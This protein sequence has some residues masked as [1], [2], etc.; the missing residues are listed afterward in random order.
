MISNNLIA[1]GD[2]HVDMYSPFCRAICK[3]PGAT[4][5]GLGNDSSSTRARRAFLGFLSNLKDFIPIVCLGEVDCNSLFW[6]K[7]ISDNRFLNKSV[8]ALMKF[9]SETD[10]K[11]IISSVIPPAVD[12]Y[13]V[14]QVRSHVTSSKAE[15]TEIVQKFNNLLNLRS[16]T[17]GHLYL[18]ITTDLLNSEGVLDMTYAKSQHKT[19]LDAKKVKPIIERKLLEAKSIYNNL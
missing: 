12:N 18:D 13:Q 8:R 4:A 6:H 15:R 7:K 17:Y 14:T 10:M 2:S 16:I 9:L 5:Y 19:H 1:I 3:V 11:F